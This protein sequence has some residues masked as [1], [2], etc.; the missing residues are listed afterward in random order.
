MGLLHE[1]HHSDIDAAVERIAAA[2]TG[3]GLP[4]GVNASPAELPRYLELGMSLFLCFTDFAGL[5]SAARA[6]F[7][8]VRTALA[9]TGS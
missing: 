7:E 5:A 3:V 9:G 6:T 2:A 4:V 8:G 1:P